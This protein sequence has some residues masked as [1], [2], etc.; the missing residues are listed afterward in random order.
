MILDDWNQD[1]SIRIG[2]GNGYRQQ[3]VSISSG[4][5]CALT[6]IGPGGMHPSYAV[7]H[8][9]CWIIY[10]AWKSTT[11]EHDGDVCLFAV[12][13]GTILTSSVLQ[14]LDPD[15]VW[16]YWSQPIAFFVVWSNMGQYY[17]WPFVEQRGV[18]VFSDAYGLQVL[19]DGLAV[20]DTAI[21]IRSKVP[22]EAMEIALWVAAIN[23]QDDA[24][25][26]TVSVNDGAVTY[27]IYT[28]LN[29]DGNP[30]FGTKY[31]FSVIPCG[32]V[33][34]LQTMLRYVWSV[35]PTSGVDIEIHRVK[36]Y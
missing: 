28:S 34:P 24:S 23:N 19:N 27:A 4:R 17:L 15:S 18:T 9:T 25:T 14:S 6:V 20:V 8:N 31:V 7:V 22:Q 16:D 29:S 1:D 32:L 21:D 5:Q 11:A 36:L 26:L 35:L 2:V 13:T 12:P 3:I 33:G 10:A 30:T